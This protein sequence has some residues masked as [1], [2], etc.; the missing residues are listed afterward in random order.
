MSTTLQGYRAAPRPLGELVAGWAR[1]P[2]APARL[3]VSDI[4][5]DSR[6][7]SPGAL[8][9]AARGRTHHG[10]AFAP[11]AVARGACAV[12]YEPADDTAMPTLPAQ[13]F[14][15]PLPELTARAGLIADRF[16]GA[17]SERLTV[18]GITGTN[19]KTTCAWLLAQA[20][21]RCG[22]ECGYMGTLGV[23]L[24]PQLSPLPHTTP[25]AVMVHR[26]LA[27]L[28]AAGASCL[29]MEVSSH[30]LDQGRVN[31]VRFRTAAFTN[32]TRDHLDYHGTMEH[33]GAAKARLFSWPGLSSRVI[34]FDDPFGAALARAASP[35]GLILT[36]RAAADRVALPQGA[37]YVR[38]T[39]VQAESTGLTIEVESSWGAVELAVN[40]VGEFNVEN[41][42]TVLAV[43]LAWSV[44][45]REAARA[46]GKVHAAR[47]R[48]EMFGGR[49]RSPLAIVDYA[50]TPDALANALRAARLHCRGQ[51]RV[52]FGCGGDRD[53][54][55]RPLM[56]RIAAELAD[57]I[58]L[59][60][61]NPRSEAPQRIVADIV[62][63]IGATAPLTIEHDRALAIRVA[64]QRSAPD[65][66]VL[67]AGKGHEDYQVTGQERRPFRDQAIVADELA[68][69]LS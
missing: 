59:T 4:T 29:S 65:D 1:V 3:M 58:V 18:A 8:F 52:V 9:L 26:Q 39:R 32:L 44:P 48:M 28:A 45:L 53:A 19:G 47:G 46:L 24:P 42:L 38:A 10:L 12:L 56:G 43:L 62:A 11:E 22:R 64:L 17:P 69:L 27:A 35:A 50:H 31:G 67:I 41:A 60:D 55:K 63:G 15:A 54:G 51:L 34:N 23:G 13:V 40:L 49:G 36:T 21:Q 61:D 33:Y 30:A 14:S 57:D 7:A 20:L 2:E 66:V 68:G 37:Q 6:A 25:D 5:L 16:F